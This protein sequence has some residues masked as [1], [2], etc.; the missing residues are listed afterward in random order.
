[1]INFSQQFERNRL[2]IYLGVMGWGL[3]GV[4]IGFVIIQRSK[5]QYIR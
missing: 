1:M 3:L 4:V 2:L 5:Q